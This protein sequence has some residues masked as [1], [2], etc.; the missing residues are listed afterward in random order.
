M[1]R[2][3]VKIVTISGESASGDRQAVRVYPEPL[4]KKKFKLASLS[5]IKAFVTPSKNKL[6]SL[7]CCVFIVL[8]DISLPYIML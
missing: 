2:H 8:I 5:L 6:N 1:A 4:K 7:L 3:N